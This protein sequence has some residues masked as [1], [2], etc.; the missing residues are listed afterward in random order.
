MYKWNMWRKIIEKLEKL[1]TY[2]DAEQESRVWSKD[3]ENTLSEVKQHI[4]MALYYAF[5]GMKDEAKKEAE[6][7]IQKVDTENRKHE[8]P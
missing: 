2:I 8:L 6:N 3:E 5:Y 1:E 7:Y 4:V